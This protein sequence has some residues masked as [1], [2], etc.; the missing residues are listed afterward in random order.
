MCV[1]LTNLAVIFHMI[2][3]LRLEKTEFLVNPVGLE[4]LSDLKLFAD[5]PLRFP[6]IHLCQLLAAK[7]C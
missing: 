7:L 3:N 4:A 5:G 6:A 2:Y 1:F